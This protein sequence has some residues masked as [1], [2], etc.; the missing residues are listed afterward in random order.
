MVS[1]VGQALPKSASMSAIAISPRYPRRPADWP[2]PQQHLILLDQSS[3]LSASS[4]LFC[5]VLEA[6]SH[7][8]SGMSA[9]VINRLAR[10][11]S[12][13]LLC[14]PRSGRQKSSAKLQ[15]IAAGFTANP[16]MQCIYSSVS[17]ASLQKTGVLLNSAGDFREFPAKKFEN[18]APGDFRHLEKPPIG[19]PFC[20]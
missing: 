10:D 8:I 17:K 1:R 16:G 18:G 4:S 11:A 7:L 2:R 19:G 14:L 9:W 3:K 13:S 12:V 5:F 15:L 6:T 20:H